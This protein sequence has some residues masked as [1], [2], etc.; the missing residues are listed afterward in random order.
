MAY[1]TGT[2]SS[3]EDLFNI[4]QTF[5]VAEGWTLDEYSTTNSWL[6]MNNGSVF[7]QFRW[8]SNGIAAM[9]QSLAFISSAVAPGNHTDDSGLGIVDA[10]APYDANV[11]TSSTNTRALFLPSGSITS[12]HFFT[13]DTT[14]HIHCVIQ[15]SPGVYYHWSMGTIDKRGD[16]TGGEYA[17]GDE[18]TDT[19]GAISLEGSVWMANRAT[20]T[21]SNTQFS[22]H[23]EGLPGQNASGKW[24]VGLATNVTV[25]DNAGQNDRAGNPRMAGWGASYGAGLHPA[26]SQARYSLLDGLLPLL[27]IEIWYKYTSSSNLHQMYLLGYAPDVYVCNI[28]SHADASEV[29]IGSDVFMLFPARQKGISHGNMGFAYKKVV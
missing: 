21:S 4:L 18:D 20:V 12:Y 11:A 16:W 10:S 23:I 15:T 29:T 1:E 24:M 25:G 14:Q 8:G 6:A 9:Y 19:G 7:V 26:L 27:P 13:D 2:A 3:P 5:A 22:M 28:A 17:T